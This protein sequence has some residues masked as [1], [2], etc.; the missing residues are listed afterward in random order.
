M[1]KLENRAESWKSEVLKLIEKLK[2][3]Y[4]VV[5]RENLELKSGETWKLCAEKSIA[6]RNEENGLNFKKYD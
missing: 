4:L 3:R 5:L 2:A 1:Q 6:Q